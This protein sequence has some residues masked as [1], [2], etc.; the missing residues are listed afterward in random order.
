MK[1]VISIAIV[2]VAGG[3]LFWATSADKS[4]GTVAAPVVAGGNLPRAESVATELS[5]AQIDQTTSSA[6]HQPQPEL[7]E[8]DLQ[9]L[10]H[11][12]ALINAWA[13]ERGYDWDGRFTLSYESMNDE[14]LRALADQH[15]PKAH[16]VLAN[17]IL[18]DM[19][20]RKISPDKLITAE[21]HLY[22]ASMLGYTETLNR[23]SELMHRKSIFDLKSRKELVLEAYKFAYVSKLR[24]DFNSNAELQG[25]KFTS[26][27]SAEEEK[28]VLANADNTYREFSQQR[29]GLGLSEFNNAPAPPEALAKLTRMANKIAKEYADML[30]RDIDS[31]KKL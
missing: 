10:P 4:V 27:L 5:P 17:R 15:D 12:V 16:L 29:Q 21:N 19:N 14:T 22:A 6:P 7:T 13:E 20:V 30:T 26:P 9:L 25:L 1:K 24:G 31:N 11:E 18:G 3:V 23:L 8:A 2:C 28:K